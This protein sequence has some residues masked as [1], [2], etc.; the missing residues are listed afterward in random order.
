M[1]RNAVLRSARQSSALCSTV[2]CSDV[3]CSLSARRAP[4]VAN[5]GGRR[6]GRDSA[7]QGGA[8]YSEGAL[9]SVHCSEGVLHS[10]RCRLRAVNSLEQCCVHSPVVA[11]LGGADGP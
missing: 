3:Q 1:Q 2:Q 11:S 5:A 8:L 4:T 7:A 9:Y 10:A 6:K